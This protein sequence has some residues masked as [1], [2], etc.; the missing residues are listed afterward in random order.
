MLSKNISLQ[1]DILCIDGKEVPL[2]SQEG[3]ALLSS[4]WMKVGWNQRHH[5]NFKWMG[6]PVLQL[7]NDLLRLQEIIFEI[8]PDVII[9]TGI[10]MGGSMLFYASLVKAIG[11]GRVIGIDVDLRPT[12]RKYIEESVLSPFITLVDGDSS[13]PR[14]VDCFQI[15]DEKV[16]VVLDSNH[17]KKHVAKELEIF[18]PLVSADSYLIVCDGFKGEVSDVPRGKERWREDNPLKAVD[19]FLKNHPEFFRDKEH[20]ITHLTG[21]FLKKT[22]NN[23]STRSSAEVSFKAALSSPKQSSDVKN[24]SS[25]RFSEKQ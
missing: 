12:N 20:P 24:L 18:A 19:D 7:P 15:E 6:A 1:S 23:V 4:L 5:Y 2:Y 21:G 3:F 17:S 11:H 9:E 8:K 13:N 22:V 10:A 14:V 16:L 25:Q